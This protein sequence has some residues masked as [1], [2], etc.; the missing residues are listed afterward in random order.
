M[1]G[2]EDDGK[3]EY[4]TV[5]SVAENG[6]EVSEDEDERMEVMFLGSGNK[7]VSFDMGVR[8]RINRT[9]GGNIPISIVNFRL[10]ATLSTAQCTT[11]PDA[12][13]D[14]ATTR[15]FALTKTTAATYIGQHHED[16]KIIENQEQTVIKFLTQDRPEPT[17]VHQFRNKRY[18]CEKI[19]MEIGENGI[20]EEK[21]GYFYEMI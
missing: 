19:E 8:Q 5:Q 10:Q 12:N 11:D 9:P 20:K 4:L 1:E 3:S 13:P 2:E 16:A 14:T 7:V 17:K 15:S 6:G 18:L 21:T